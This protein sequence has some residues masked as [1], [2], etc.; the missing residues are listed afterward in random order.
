[1]NVPTDLLRCTG[2]QCC[3]QLCP[4]GAITID[5]DTEGFPVPVIDQQKCTD[6]GLCAERCPSNCGLTWHEPK[7]VMGAR[8]IRGDSALAESSSG[9]ACY[10]IAE[11]FLTGGNAVV[12]GAALDQDNVCRH[13]GISDI[14]ELHR[15]QG[16]K[17]VQS[18]TG[19][20]YRQAEQALRTG[21]KVLFTGTPCQIAGLYQY[22]G[23]QYDN[24]F[25]IDLIC[26][27]VPSPGL[28]RLYIQYLEEKER[29]GKIIYFNFRPKAKLGWGVGSFLI[30]T[31][32]K[33]RF[34][35]KFDNPYIISFIADNCLRECCYQCQFTRT[36]RIGDLTAG[37][38]WGVKETHT[39]F[40]DRRGSSVALINTPKG[41]RLAGILTETCST[42]DTALDKVVPYQ[43]M[44]SRPARRPESR[45]RLLRDIRGRGTDIFRQEEF[46]Y[47]ANVYWKKWMRYHFRWFLSAY[48]TVRRRLQVRKTRG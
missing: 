19:D 1:M 7:R 39:E 14:S 29:D 21:K 8:Y 48:N 31:E 45:D 16:S 38:L 18:D 17:Y 33:T 27:G 10:A 9:G 28:F 15:L 20:T 12:F 40:Y 35:P 22:L 4:V 36:E 46:K 3:R 24:L 23:T 47:P 44:L 30:K 2:C 34:M 42:I 41:E 26:H 13:I 5:E 32:T 43:Q 6:C 37:D 25:T 11:R